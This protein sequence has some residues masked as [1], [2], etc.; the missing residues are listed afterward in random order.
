[1]LQVLAKLDNNT[2]ESLRIVL[3]KQENPLGGGL[4]IQGIRKA[5]TEVGALLL[6]FQLCDATRGAVVVSRV[7]AFA[8]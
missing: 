3:T 1:M 6:V 8:R 5:P 4:V 2:L 7:L